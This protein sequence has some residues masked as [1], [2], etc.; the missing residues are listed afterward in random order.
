[1]KNLDFS[2][3]SDSHNRKNFN[4]NKEKNNELSAITNQKKFSEKDNGKANSKKN[5]HKVDI[6]A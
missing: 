6:N 5:N 4:D 3:H 1:M 2:F